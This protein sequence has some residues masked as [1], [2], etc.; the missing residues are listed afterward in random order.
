MFFCTCCKWESVDFCYGFFT[1]WVYFTSPT[2]GVKVLKDCDRNVQTF[3]L[4]MYVQ[5]FVLLV[6]PSLLLSS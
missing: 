6:M 5:L 1:G 2:N 4:I 3:K